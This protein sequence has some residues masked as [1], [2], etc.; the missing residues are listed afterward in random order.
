[1]QG[2]APTLENVHYAPPRKIAG[3]EDYRQPETNKS[4]MYRFR[5]RVYG[6]DIP[7][8]VNCV[9]LEYVSCG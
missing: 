8:N 3:L 2:Y 1:M 7:Q 9:T 4:N 6:K 5:K